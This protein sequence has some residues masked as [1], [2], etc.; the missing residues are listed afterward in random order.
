[1]TE[2][3]VRRSTDHASLWKQTIT[4]VDGRFS[5]YLPGFLHLKTQETVS[6]TCK[7][8]FSF[9][10]VTSLMIHKFYDCRFSL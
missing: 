10:T 4:D 1:M 5:E 2:C 3:T 8:K 7:I 9:H 6:Y